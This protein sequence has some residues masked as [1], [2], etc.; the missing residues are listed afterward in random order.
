MNIVLYM[1]VKT[2]LGSLNIMTVYSAV[3]SSLYSI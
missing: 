3:L 1:L 2:V